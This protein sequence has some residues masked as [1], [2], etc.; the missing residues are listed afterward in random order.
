MDGCSS[1][2]DEMELCVA[3]HDLGRLCW[4]L[5]LHFIKG[6]QGTQGCWQAGRRARGRGMQN[7][8]RL[9]YCYSKLYVSSAMHMQGER[10]L[11]QLRA[12]TF[13]IAK[14]S[15]SGRWFPLQ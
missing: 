5:P 4:G 3:G 1:L 14:G 9:F 10:T 7:L 12:L 6:H 11:Q 8:I 15:S 2:L 13:C